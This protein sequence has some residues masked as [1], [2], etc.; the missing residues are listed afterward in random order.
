MA[1]LSAL[2]FVREMA[3]ADQYPAGD[4]YPAGRF[5]IA[6][7]E[8]FFGAPTDVQGFPTRDEAEQYLSLLRSLVD[9]EEA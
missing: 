5:E 8:S 6:N 2:P 1:D 4:D 3:P 9:G 7:C